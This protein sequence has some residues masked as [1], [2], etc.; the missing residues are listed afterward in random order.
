MAVDVAADD[1][2]DGADVEFD[3]SFVEFEESLSF[4]K[5]FFLFRSFRTASRDI[6]T[7]KHF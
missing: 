5:F 1:D 7:L 2:D 3:F 6:P 4:S